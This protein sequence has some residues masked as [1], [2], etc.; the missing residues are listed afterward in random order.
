[1]SDNGVT[2]GG[3]TYQ[4]TPE[5]LA[6]AAADTTNT[7]S[8]INDQLTTIKGYVYS[9]EASWRGIAHD[10]FVVLMA[11]YD[12]LALLLQNALTAIGSGLKG[13]Y[14]NYIGSEDAN[15]TNLNNVGAG[16][17]AGHS[18]PTANLT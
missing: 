15:L 16:M 6:G 18:G 11:D 13:N 2:V 10:R 14:I 9:L 7:A 3:V 12:R 1:M 4:V 5:Y 8:Q 17:P